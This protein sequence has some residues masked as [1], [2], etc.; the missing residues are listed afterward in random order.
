MKR[1]IFALLCT[2]LL[3]TGCGMMDGDYLSVTPHRDDSDTIQTGTLFAENYDQLQHILEDMVNAGTESIVINT[4]EY[5]QDQLETDIQTVLEHIRKE[6]PLGTYAISSA[7]YEIGT[8]VGLPAVSINLEYLHGRSEI[9]KIQKTEDIEGAETIIHGVLD[10]CAD[11]VVLLIDRYMETDLVQLVEDYALD[12]PDL[13]METPQVAVG[14]Y[15]ETGESRL[16]ELK[17][18]YQTSRDALRQM[19]T[20]VQRVFVS[21]ALYVNSD[22]TDLQKYSQLYTFLAERF[23]YQYERSI[24]PAY[25]LLSHGVGD[26]EAFASVYAAMCRRVE[27]PCQIVSGTRNGESRF[28]NRVQ[29]DG[30][31]YHVDLIQV[32][33]AGEF[34]IRTDAQMQ[35]YVWDFSAF[36][37]RENA[38]PN[39]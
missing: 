24:T 14:I 2:A 8:L 13:V 31:W 32:K 20:Q 12:H 9:M 5:P 28:W 6:F 7:E 23:P 34:R 15:P 29:V 3:L 16:V 11:G 1:K 19:Q 17:F 21:A 39:H 36:P 25:S 33:D 4:Y 18:T 22:S 35:G 10:Q 38:I 37:S 30:T 26:S 27:I